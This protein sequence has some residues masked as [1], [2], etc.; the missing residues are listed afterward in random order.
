MLS[1]C[2]LTLPLLAQGRPYT[3]NEVPFSAVPVRH[4]VAP[5]CTLAHRHPRRYPTF[6]GT[7]EASPRIK[8]SYSLLQPAVRWQPCHTTVDMTEPRL[9]LCRTWSEG[10]VE[11][12][13]VLADSPS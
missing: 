10:L 11:P 2:N 4:H 13:R 6:F 9:R 1:L 3:Q 5:E 8:L 12:A 7:E